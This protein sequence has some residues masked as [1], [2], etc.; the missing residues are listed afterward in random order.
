MGR[1]HPPR[2]RQQPLTVGRQGHPP[3]RP[4]EEIGT[5]LPFQAP[6]VAAQR[7]L[8]HV[9][10]DGG[11]GEVQFLGHGDEGAEET[12]VEVGR[13]DIQGTYNRSA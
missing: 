10:P 1:Q 3:G 13:E 5:Q 11:P 4:Y 12:G 2:V 7:L 9:Q 8:G 6:D